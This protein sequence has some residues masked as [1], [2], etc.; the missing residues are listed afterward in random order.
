[1]ATSSTN[2]EEYWEASMEEIVQNSAT[3]FTQLPQS[4]VEVLR[5]LND[6]VTTVSTVST[7]S[8]DIEINFGDESEA[9][10]NKDHDSDLEIGNERLSRLSSGFNGFEAMGKYDHYRRMVD[11][12]S[13]SMNRT[14]DTCKIQ[15][16]ADP[17]K[18][19]HCGEVIIAWESAI[20]ELKQFVESNFGVESKSAGQNVH[21]LLMNYLDQV[22]E[23]QDDVQ[24]KFHEFN[25]IQLMKPTKFQEGMRFRGEQ[26]ET[27]CMICYESYME[28]QMV[29]VLKCGHH[30]HKE[31][32]DLWFAV[33]VQ[34]S[35]CRR[36]F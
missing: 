3:M 5:M 17:L 21:F 1:M 9:E 16:D 34:C 10:E 12:M 20:T 24:K 30:T 8:S 14:I 18:K 11:R 6:P 15:M 35:Y 4:E 19:A 22:I 23:F 25:R 7:R 26:W 31:C 28:G 27:E 29:R 36:D 2:S 33:K 32:G 13:E